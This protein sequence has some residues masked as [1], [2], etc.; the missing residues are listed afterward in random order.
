MAVEPVGNLIEF[1]DD[2]ARMEYGA[3]AAAYDLAL[4]LVRARQISGLSQAELAHRLGTS[5]AYVAKLE[6]GE[7]HPAIRRVGAILAAIWARLEMRAIP[8]SPDEDRA[9]ANSTPARTPRQGKHRR[10]SVDR[11]TG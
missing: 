11:V 5:Q 4:A 3:W 6:S 1:D 10:S 2:E 7:G 9:A 8:L